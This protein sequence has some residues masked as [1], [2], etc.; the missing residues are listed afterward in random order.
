MDKY[1]AR[2]LE[3][4]KTKM[5]KLNTQNRVDIKVQV[6]TFGDAWVNVMKNVWKKVRKKAYYNVWNKVKTPVWRFICEDLRK[7]TKLK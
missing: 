5:I 4:H 2:S 6:K 7:H 1:L 3:P